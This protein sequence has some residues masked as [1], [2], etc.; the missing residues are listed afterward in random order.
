MSKGFRAGLV[1][2]FLLPVIVTSASAEGN[3]RYQVVPIPPTQSDTG[4][5]ALIIDTRDG[6]LWQ[7][8]QGMTAGGGSAEGITYLGRI[9]PGKPGETIPIERFGGQPQR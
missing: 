5:R 8:W 7:W 1:S 3:G 2:C 9:N 4:A 6:H